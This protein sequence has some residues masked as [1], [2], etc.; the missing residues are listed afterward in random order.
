MNNNHAI[1]YIPIEVLN[2]SS[3]DTGCDGCVRACCGQQRVKPEKWWKHFLLQFES[4]RWRPHKSMM[5]LAARTTGKFDE[6][7]WKASLT[8]TAGPMRSTGCCFGAL[9]VITESV[10]LS[11]VYRRSLIVKFSSG[12]TGRRTFYNVF[13]IDGS[14][15]MVQDETN[16]NQI[17]T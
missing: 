8:S 12:F 16:D 5:N 11:W 9:R 13:L 1:K 17:S 10:K 4:W 15:S 3:M 7:H 6:S 2:Q 14:G